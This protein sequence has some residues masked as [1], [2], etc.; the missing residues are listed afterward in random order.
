[1]GGARRRLRGKVRGKVRMMSLS[2]RWM[3]QKLAHPAARSSGRSSSFAGHWQTHT[4]AAYPSP[5]GRFPQSSVNHLWLRKLK[6]QTVA[7]SRGK[8]RQAKRK[9]CNWI[10][11]HLHFGESTYSL[12]DPPFMPESPVF[13]R[14]WASVKAQ[15][16]SRRSRRWPSVISSLFV[17]QT[18][19]RKARK[20]R[21]C[22]RESSVCIWFDGFSSKKFGIKTPAALRED[23]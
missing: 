15:G 6:G 1:M 12:R 4:G 16:S 11:L 22:R 17:I 21:C 19:P 23:A 3:L 20:S 8:M 9:K 18:D 13:A 10:F 14:E 7:R 2:D 5:A